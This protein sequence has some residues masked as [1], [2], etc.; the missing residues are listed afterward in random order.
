VQTFQHI[1]HFR[2]ACREAHRVLKERGRL[3]NYSLHI[4]PILQWIY[5]AAGRT[6]HKE[7][8]IK[9]LFHLTRANNKQ[10]DVLSEIFSGSVKD[11]YTECLF[12][13]DLRLTFT[14]REG[15]LV[16]QLDAHLGDF[17]ALGRW[18]AR[19]RSFEAVKS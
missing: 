1:P 7:G 19:Q 18:L 6:Y 9:G 5:R 8:T 11:R 14:G 12:H 4:T 10:R 15:N 13:P 16:G 2:Q 17:P 3:E